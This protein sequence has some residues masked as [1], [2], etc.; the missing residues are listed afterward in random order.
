MTLWESQ[1]LS[2][3][4]EGEEV[5]DL[6]P[7]S[8]EEARD[9]WEMYHPPHDDEVTDEEPPVLP[10]IDALP[11][12]IEYDDRGP[13]DWIVSGPCEDNIG[14]GRYFATELEAFQWACSKWGRNRV[15]RVDV[16]PGRWGVLVKAI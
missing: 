12:H 11:E 4:D 6:P 16:G 15:R 2:P 5:T 14:N 7:M 3:T 9:L 8:A 1:L 10:T 13:N